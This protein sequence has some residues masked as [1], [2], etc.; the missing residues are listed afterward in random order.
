MSAGSPRSSAAKRLSAGACGS[1]WS[2]I[3]W[4]RLSVRRNLISCTM[5]VFPKKAKLSPWVKNTAYWKK[6][7]RRIRTD[8][9]P[10]SPLL[11][12]GGKG[13]GEKIN[14]AEGMSR[15]RQ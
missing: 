5:K 11:R 6:A 3:K 12:G 8:P 2:R 7:D 9:Y 14:L 4:R 1:K 13:G 10:A 15:A